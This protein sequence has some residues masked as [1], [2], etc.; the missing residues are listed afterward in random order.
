MAYILSAERRGPGS[1]KASFAHYR[2]YPEA[3]E[4]RFPAGAFRL[5][6]SE[7]YYDPSDVRSP[8]DARLRWLK[9]AEREAEKAT[10]RQAVDVII[11][12]RSAL[13]DAD[14]EFSYRDVDS[15]E[16]QLAD[17]SWGHRDW[18]YDEFRLAES[19]Q[20]NHE[21]EWFGPTGTGRWLIV[22]ADVDFR[23]VPDQSMNRPGGVS[24][25]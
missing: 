19:G 17:G 2:K 5:A 8:H 23:V 22:A 10:G 18:R 11:T 24:A 7:W 12:L 1:T 3:S 6:S 14:L 13:A 21:I 4:H 20:M 9:V 25:G 15:Y 16:L